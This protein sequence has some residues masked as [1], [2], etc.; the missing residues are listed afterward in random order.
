MTIYI[1]YIQCFSATA[2]VDARNYII[3][4]YTIFIYFRLVGYIATCTVYMHLQLHNV[5]AS[6]MVHV[7]CKHMPFMN[8][9]TKTITRT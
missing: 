1:L 3:L 2:S 5:K 4:Y 8:C 7:Y 9:V 6:L